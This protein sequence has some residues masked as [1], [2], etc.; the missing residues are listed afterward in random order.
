MA[1]F[2]NRNTCCTVKR[3]F[4]WDLMIAE[5]PKIWHTSNVHK[6]YI[7][8]RIHWVCSNFSFSIIYIKK[9]NLPNYT[10]CLSHFV[11]ICATKSVY[12]CLCQWLWRDEHAFCLIWV[13]KNAITFSKMLH[14]CETFQ[15]I[16]ILSAWW[17]TIFF[18]CMRPANS[19]VNIL[20]QMAISLHVE[21]I[22]MFIAC[23]LH[24]QGDLPRERKNTKTFFHFN[25]NVITQ[26]LQY[27]L[28]I[29]IYDFM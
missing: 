7:H 13:N 28:L 17:Q 9:K 20:R 19:Q 26:K 2:Y 21:S 16:V 27:I 25:A 5:V 8:N 29:N 24:F 10:R 22:N 11:Q 15:W 18:L 14:I 4:Q 6:A 23:L 1:T 3:Y 12:V